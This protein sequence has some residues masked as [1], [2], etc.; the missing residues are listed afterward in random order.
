MIKKYEKSLELKFLSNRR[1]EKANEYLNSRLKSKYF[2][3]WSQIYEKKQKEE[4]IFIKN[5]V[6]LHFLFFLIGSRC[7]RF[8]LS[9]IISSENQKIVD[10]LSKVKS[11]F[12]I[13]N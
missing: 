5:R 12:K 4:N 8:S 11:L 6:A 13:E 2:S 7:K 10:N 3:K 1:K 9:K